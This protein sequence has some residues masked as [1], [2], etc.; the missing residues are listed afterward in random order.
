MKEKGDEYLRLW[1]RILTG[2]VENKEEEDSEQKSMLLLKAV[3]DID[4]IK[5]RIRKEEEKLYNITKEL[6][7]KIC[8]LE[9]KINAK[10]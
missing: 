8:Q 10:S 5:E 3:R 4:I 9:D 6:T 1:E 2:G 7:E